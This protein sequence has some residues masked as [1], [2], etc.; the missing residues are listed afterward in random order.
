LYFIYRYALPPYQR[1]ASLLFLLQS[2]GSLAAIFVF[3]VVQS[4]GIDIHLV[5]MPSVAGVFAD[6]YR[7][8]S[9]NT[10]AKTRF[11]NLFLP[12]GALLCGFAAVLGGIDDPQPAVDLK[13]LAAELAASGADD[14]FSV[15]FVARAFR[16]CPN[17]A[18]GSTANDYQWGLHWL[19][20]SVC[21]SSDGVRDY[22]RRVASTEAPR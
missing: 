11:D 13:R 10:F 5:Q 4:A 8:D 12:F 7:I 19:R 9:A 14:I 17:Q 15:L 16:S 1:V 18:Q 21:N 3:C 22:R 6:V 20:H 2:A